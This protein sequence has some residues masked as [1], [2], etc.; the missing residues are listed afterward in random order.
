[1]QGFYVERDFE[2]RSDNYL[3]LGKSKY[4]TYSEVVFVAI[5]LQHVMNMG[6]VRLYR[7]LPRYVLNGWIFDKNI[8]YK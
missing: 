5:G 8:E 1:M 4:I 2:A 3:F 7:I 6:A